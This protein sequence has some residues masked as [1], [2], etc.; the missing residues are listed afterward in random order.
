MKLLTHITLRISLFL[1]IVMTLWACLF[2]T[3]IINEINDEVDDSLEDYSEMIIT[4]KL[5][6]ESVPEHDN[7]TNNTFFIRKVT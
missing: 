1:L 4:R 2:Y 6:G 5:A 3:A 7:G